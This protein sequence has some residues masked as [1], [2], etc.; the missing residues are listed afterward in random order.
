MITH[1]I[2]GGVIQ[3]NN[4]NKVTNVPSSSL[5][6]PMASS[7]GG[8]GGEA[9][10]NFDDKVT[11]SLS[12]LSSFHSSPNEHHGQ[13]Y[14][15]S[16][17]GRISN[18][19]S[20]CSNNGGNLRSNNNNNKDNNVAHKMKM[21][22]I[23]IKS[24]NKKTSNNNRGNGSGEASDDGNDHK[25]FQFLGV[26]PSSTSHAPVPLPRSYIACHSTGSDNKILLGPS[27]GESES[28]LSVPLTSSSSS[29][30]R[31]GGV[32]SHAHAHSSGDAHGTN[33]NVRG[34]LIA[35]NGSL[36]SNQPQQ[37]DLTIT[38]P[39]PPA[40][41][42][43][44]LTTIQSPSSSSSPSSVT[45]PPSTLQSASLESQKAI[46]TPSWSKQ[47]Q[48][49]HHH[50]HH[51]QQQQQ[52]AKQSIRVTA[53][54]TKLPSSNIG[55]NDIQPA[56][57]HHYD[58]TSRHSQIQGSPAS[59]IVVSSSS[60]STLATSG[61]SIIKPA[62]SLK[63]FL[64]NNSPPRAPRLRPAN[65][66]RLRVDTSP[67]I[68]VGI[69]LTSSLSAS[70]P[71]STSTSTANGGSRV[72]PV[73]IPYEEFYDDDSSDNN[74]AV[75]HNRSLSSSSS[76]SVI[77]PPSSLQSPTSSRSRQN[78]NNVATR[79]T[80]MVS[81]PPTLL[82]AMERFF[83]SSSSRLPIARIAA[84][85]LLSSPR[86]SS[87]ASSSSSTISGGAASSTSAHSSCPSQAQSM[88]VTTS[89]VST[90][91]SVSPNEY[92]SGMTKMQH[93]ISSL[94]LS[95]SSQISQAN[96]EWSTSLSQVDRR[97]QERIDHCYNQCHNAVSQQR[98]HDEEESQMIN[99]MI[100]K[101]DCMTMIKAQ[102]ANFYDDIAALKGQVSTLQQ[103]QRQEVQCGTKGYRNGKNVMENK[104]STLTV[105]TSTPMETSTIEEK[106]V[107]SQ[108][109]DDTANDAASPSL[110]SSESPLSRLTPIV[111][112]RS[113]LASTPTNDCVAN[114]QNSS[115]SLTT[116]SVWHFSRDPDNNANVVRFVLHV[117]SNG[118]VSL[119]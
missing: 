103:Q 4:P 102:M 101:D 118:V 61:L 78:N 70:S 116:P 55:G 115:T 5:L 95:I 73:P 67:D 84:A 82:Q 74:V 14:G 54:L 94:T 27:M 45:V 24:I 34:G 72:A 86:S 18:G 85:P 2:T 57:S 98:R 119:S 79:A 22:N 88:R 59:A 90:C 9:L 97:L 52:Q 12:S 62:R 51:H 41:S 40:L 65:A 6:S 109:I 29:S 99:N 8:G 13:G 111:V 106:S 110:Q 21:N 48:N 11:S 104:L 113:S 112:D 77:S 107:A 50:H 100:T 75:T 96:R 71:S 53:P 81:M 66:H 46:A 80:M 35:L 89:T 91:E 43:N 25:I 17:C 49:H 114:N 20:N 47:I 32:V 44:L 28:K 36:A 64:A 92:E 15:S 38:S 33:R 76:C 1:S 63:E 37:V 10:T 16:T 93:E 117:T 69:P 68:N 23:N 60:S 105:A 58:V 7:G 56:H 31:E 39:S 30:S 3:I 87:I 19:N 42:H 83:M 108:S 26:D